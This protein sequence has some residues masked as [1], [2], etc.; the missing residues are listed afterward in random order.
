MSKR[1]RIS[2]RVYAVRDTFI[3]LL[4]A[5]LGVLGLSAGVVYFFA[6]QQAPFASRPMANSDFVFSVSPQKTS[7]KIE[8]VQIDGPEYV[9]Q[10]ILVRFDSTI[11]ETRKNDIVNLIAAQSVKS[12]AVPEGLELVSL[13]DGMD[14]DEA[15]LYFSNY[16]E[17]HYAEPDYIVQ[18]NLI[19]NDPS[20]NL[21]W[22]MLNIGQTNGTAGID[23]GATDAWLKTAGGDN[24]VIGVTDTGIAYQHPDLRDNVWINAN[25]IPDNQLDDDNNGW[26]DDIYGIDT[27]NN[28]SDPQDDNRHGTH[29]F[30]TIAAT[31]NNAIGVTGVAWQAKVVGCKFL[32]DNGKGF[33]SDAIRCLTY[34]ADLKASGVN[35]VATNNSWGGSHFSQ[36]LYDA[37]EHHRQHDILFV[38]AA[39]N[40]R[41]NTDLSPHYPSSYD[42]DNIISVAAIDHN[43]DLAE[44]SNYGSETVDVAAPGAKIYSTLLDGQ[45]GYLS[46][47][48]MAAPHVSGLIA[49]FKSNQPHLSATELKD[50]V[51]TTGIDDARL[52]TKV[53]TAKRVYAKLPKTDRDADG[54]PDRWELL[55]DLDPENA[56]D[57]AQDAD[58]DGLNNL[59]EFSAGTDPNNSDTDGD[60]LSDGDEVNLFDTDATR[61]DTDDDGISDYQEIK[62]Y[63]TN[64]LL[65]DSDGD[66]LLDG[67]EIYDYF[68]KPLISDTD[69]DGILDGWEVKHGLDPND[70]SD[71]GHDPDEDGLSNLREYELGT[72]PDHPDSDADGLNDGDEVNLHLTNPLEGDSDSDGMPDGWEVKYKLN[73]LDSSDAAK[74]AD[75]DAH[76]NW[77]EYK[78]GSNPQDLNSVPPILPWVTTQGDSAHTAYIPLALRADNFNV[79]WAKSVGMSALNPVASA[80]GVVFVSTRSSQTSPAL[81]A[82]NSLD[83]EIIWQKT[84]ED[85]FAIN[86]PAYDDGKIYLQID[87]LGK[88]DGLYAYQAD[89]GSEVFA[90]DAGDPNTGFAVTPHKG[91]IYQQAGNKLNSINGQTGETN[92]S[93]QATAKILPAVAQ[94]GIA[95]YSGSQFALLDPQS[96]ASRFTI[97]NSNCFNADPATAIL[98]SANT[99]LVQRG[100]CLTHYD[101]VNRSVLW[102]LTNISSAALAARH[103]H[104]YV[105][106]NGGLTEL[107][108]NNGSELW[109]WM[110]PTGLLNGNIV[111]TL[112]HVFVSSGSATYAINLTTRSSDWSIAKGG[113]LALSDEDALIIAAANGSLTSVNL[114]GDAD[115]DSMPDWWER[116]YKLNQLDA[117]DS[118]LDTDSDGLTNLREYIATSNPNDSDT[119]DDGLSDSEEVDIYFTSPIKHDSDKDGLVDADELKVHLTNPLM[120][121]TDGDDVSDGDEVT[122][123]NTDPNDSNSKPALIYSYVQSFE[124]GMPPNWVQASDAA[125]GWAISQD[126]ATD[127]EF[128][129]RSQAISHNQ[130]AAIEWTGLF[131]RGEIRFDVK[132]SA[133]ACCDKFYF[134]IDDKLVQVVANGDWQHIIVPVEQG[135]HTLRWA[136]TAD[137]ASIKYENAAWIDHLEFFVPPP[138]ASEV[139]NLLVA[140]DNKIYEYTQDGRQVRSA[141]EVPNGRNVGDLLLTDNYKIAVADPPWLKLYDPETDRWKQ[142]EV[143]AWIQTGDKRLSSLAANSKT[144]WAAIQQGGGI[145][146]FDLEGNYID[147]VL[148][149]KLY[150]DIS[151]GRDGRLYALKKLSGVVD[152]IDPVSM[153]VTKSVRLG[154]DKR[155]IAVEQDG[156][157]YATSWSHGLQHFDEQGVLI[158][159][160]DTKINAVIH[161]LDLNDSSLLVFG[162][163]FAHVGIADTDFTDVRTFQFAN[164]YYGDNAFVAFV[165]PN[166]LDSDSDGM[167]D[168][169]ERLH[170]LNKS[171]ADDAYLDPDNDS[172][173]NL[174]EY[175]AT[176]HPH[177]SDVDNDGLSDGREVNIYFTNPRKA[178]TDGDGLGDGEE[179][180]IYGTR[181]LLVDSDGDGLGDGT[182]ITEYGTAPLKFDTDEDGLPDNW[183][184]N[185]NFN[186]IFKADAA[187]DEDMDGLDNL[188]EYEYKTNPRKA[189]TDSDQLNDAAEIKQHGTDPVVRDS[190]GDR[191]FDGWE[192]QY[193]FNPLS[194]HDAEE[195]FDSD[196]FTNKEEFFAGSDPNDNL[197]IPIRKPWSDY[198][199]GAAHT[200]FMP[201]N[202]NSAEFVKR[203]EIDV[204]ANDTTALNFVTAAEGKVFVTTRALYNTHTLAVI[205]ARD[206]QVVWTK[207][208]GTSRTISPPVYANGNVYIQTANYANS[209]LRSYSIDTQQQVF[210]APYY[211]TAYQ[212]YAPVP[213]AG[214][215]LISGG[216]NVGLHSFNAYTGQQLWF[217]G[218]NNT[219]GWLPAIDDNY[220][221]SYVGGSEA[222]LTAIHRLTGLKAF[223]VP[224]PDFS[225]Q[226]WGELSAPLLGSD[227]NIIIVQAGRLLSFNLKDRAINWQ[228]ISNFKGQPALANGIVYVSDA[229]K[230]SAYDELSGEWLWDWSPPIEAIAGTMAVSNDQVFVS[231]PSATYAVDLLLHK[232][233]WSIN[234]GG[235]L[236]LSSDGVLYIAQTNGKLTAV[237]V[238]GDSDG[239]GMPNW[240]EDSHTLDQASNA[241]AV[242]DPD[243]DNLTNLQEYIANTNPKIADTDSDGLNDG[244]EINT[245]FTKPTVADTDGDAL[246]DGAEVMD[247]KTDPG[248]P[249][250]DGDGIPDG[251]EVQYS[252]NPLEHDSAMDP[253]QDG[254]TNLEEYYSNTNPKTTPS[255][256]VQTD[257]GETPSEAGGGGKIDCIYILLVLTLM[258]NYRR[259]TQ[260]KTII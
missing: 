108:T 68:T 39:G 157:I 224:D 164:S 57:A 132:V 256:Q 138:V 124:A 118:A 177:I 213:Y 146:R 235:A 71:V 119:D 152:V 14:V 185:N 147:H 244:S 44:F 196:N 9:P 210:A 27:K 42:L 153:H 114:G 2:G 163:Q 204:L 98:P 258:V 186:P 174:Q 15:R 233:T 40:N 75:N 24:I 41:R 230:L 234:K 238:S 187:A 130:T 227:D 180:N 218:H 29:V 59:A 33:T 240:W 7:I 38:A 127:G 102:E 201:I 54:M 36:A 19:P 67:E 28:D 236:T 78:A 136:F 134:Y 35:I 214:E 200:G 137:K 95:V 48:S 121:D 51:L 62:S 76:T 225:W 162:S 64:P 23:I 179:V 79:R 60:G 189:D 25:E 255:S 81:L 80:D 34:F 86:S 168:W 6:G 72:I 188:T 116:R 191:M 21:L 53:L 198:Q 128:S 16:D 115:S 151:Y 158:K 91:T 49:L 111:L 172:L 109:S 106:R 166:S 222:R 251:W 47:T 100:T 184:L 11:T 192:V 97:P 259:H 74:D 12:Y 26:V 84:F 43:G 217:A 56:G 10:Q 131:A 245:H 103:G 32:G 144:I 141:I 254:F 46:G 205:D 181:P 112:T 183:E 31:G 66:G 1:P 161:D 22:G 70:Q 231:T 129:L 104:I 133:E 61:S 122:I 228:N 82:L 99:A 211:S 8:P 45:Y 219:D 110:P 197:A 215:V 3:F 206:G 52:A 253:D 246:L 248:K 242:A 150:A 17:V 101:L 135:E 13:P 126:A 237:E 199:G 156:S 249:D 55:N 113:H 96:G 123:Y 83:G 155:G 5:V 175:L 202:L 58:N 169:W 92:W 232:H 63:L 208:L 190:D 105:I 142:T 226:Q 149:G 139:G 221:Y 209:Y 170:R 148:H 165:M 145:L 87:R 143:L 160:I 117:S 18:T 20:F 89:T 195:D 171:N 77:T 182:E 159:S 241:D 65:S 30:G 69:G 50:L 85:L 140:A 4:L 73:P 154:Y 247:Y 107:D 250:S 252:L 167:P 243:Q 260:R 120:F 93:Y 223:D 216:S 193:R 257:T 220:I 229:G 94:A 212:G 125:A 239:D 90:V 207:N 37:I 88:D 178:D 173:S 176:T 194:N 203:W